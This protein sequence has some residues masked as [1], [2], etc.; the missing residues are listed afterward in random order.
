VKD[1]SSG[2][3]QKMTNP[4]ITKGF[5]TLEIDEKTKDL[6]KEGIR[7]HIERGGYWKDFKPSKE[8]MVRIRQ[9]LSLLNEGIL[10]R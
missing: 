7:E 1:F 10:D 5:T 6:W 9:L 8:Q 2:K 4:K 3:N